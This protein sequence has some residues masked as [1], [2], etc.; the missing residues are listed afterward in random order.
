[1][2]KKYRE[3]TRAPQPLDFPEHG[4]SVFARR[5]ARPPILHVTVPMAVWSTESLESLNA[6]HGVRPKWAERQPHRELF[7]DACAVARVDR[8]N[9][10]IAL[11]DL[12]DENLAR[13]RSDMSHRMIA[14]GVTITNHARRERLGQRG[15]PS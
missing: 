15:I 10:A 1:M 4:G 11:R 3:S 9:H 8:G 12:L 13:Q 5:P 2:E 6:F 14:D 7:R